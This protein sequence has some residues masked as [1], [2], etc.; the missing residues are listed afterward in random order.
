MP[1]ILILKSDQKAIE[2]P[3]ML[4]E[5]GESKYNWSEFED[6]RKE[7]KAISCLYHPAPT[8][9]QQTYYSGFAGFLWRLTE[10]M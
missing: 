5:E 8:Y 10:I 4:S 7:R 1:D 9:P 2:L 3:G 6:N